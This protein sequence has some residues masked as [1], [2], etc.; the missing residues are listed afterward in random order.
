[1]LFRQL[2][3]P[4]SSTYTYLLADEETREAVLIDPVLEQVD[5]D[6]TLLRE[7]G[8]RL[9]LAL[10]THVHADHVTALGA[11]RERTGA[12]T[13]HSEKAGAACADQLVKHGD[14]LRFGQHELEVRETPGH[15]HGCISFVLHGADGGRPAM[16]F[17]GDALL[18]RGCGRTDF[19]QGDPRRLY[20]SVH[21]QLLSLPPDTLLYPGH[22]YKGR[23][24]TTVAEEAQW[25]PRLG[26]GRT[27]DAFVST[28]ESLGL[29]YPKKMDVAV[30]ANLHCGLPRGGA[31]GDAGGAAW[32]PVQ[33]AAGG[34][35]EV[36]PEWVAE[37]P[38][39]ARLVDVREPDEYDGELGHIARAE[40]APLAALPS[41]AASWDRG[42]PVVTICRSGGRSA[43]AALELAGL[44]FGAVASLRGGMVAWHERGLP[45]ESGSSAKDSAR[46]DA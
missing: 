26:G 37:H 12:T 4:E 9:V 17:T 11:L 22:D 15:T 40:L 28:M 5:R 19:Q 3:D 18:I 10:D 8:L 20:H 36:A 35:P 46:Q 24:V 42:T 31:S 21:E 43:K 30:P 25:N 38:G 7:L 6:V 39:A 29:P 33:T 34:F 32:A 14:R 2:F 1:M 45:V 23:T 16:A 41:L 27:V 44:G 13:V